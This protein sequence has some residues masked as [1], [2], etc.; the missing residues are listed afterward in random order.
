MRR[1]IM[2]ALVFG[3]LAIPVPTAAAEVHVPFCGIDPITLTGGIPNCTF[4]TTS[5]GV[6]SVDPANVNPCSGVVGTA[7]MVSNSITHVTVNGAG[8]VWVTST[9][10]AHFTFVPN[11]PNATNAP[12]YAGEMTFWF[13]ASLN[14]NNLV[15][16][17]TG[18]I[19]VHGTDGSTI[20]FHL[21]D[22]FNTSASGAVN[23]FSVASVTCP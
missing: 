1:L 16:H 20:T 11:A 12:S 22:H 7:T 8:D 9:S 2:L 21:L 4:T 3:V 10:T 6:V 15:F 19:V 18:N 5:H 14:Q 17:D 23:S 13:G